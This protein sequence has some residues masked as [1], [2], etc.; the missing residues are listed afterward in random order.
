MRAQRGQAGSSN[1]QKL[2]KLVG[3]WKEIKI[4]GND[5]VKS[6]KGLEISC[7]W[8]TQIVGKLERVRNRGRKR[9]G[10]ETTKMVCCGQRV[11]CLNV[12][13]VKRLRVMTRLRVWPC[14]WIEK[15]VEAEVTGG[16]KVKGLKCCGAGHPNGC[17]GSLGLGQRGGLGSSCQIFKK[18]SSLI[19][20]S[21][22]ESY[23]ER[24]R[25]V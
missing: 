8:N 21:I 2:V 18:W 5:G 23:K 7:G 24:Y 22:V 4:G 11:G 3:G 15:N 9:G 10:R 20:R 19:K 25:M 17:P 16:E 1:W 13:E 6:T 14:R 12:L